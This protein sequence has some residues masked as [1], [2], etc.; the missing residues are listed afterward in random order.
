MDTVVFLCV[1]DSQH[2]NLVY[3]PVNLFYSDK[4]MAIGKFQ[5]FVNI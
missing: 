2:F 5:K 1:D 3:F 4:V